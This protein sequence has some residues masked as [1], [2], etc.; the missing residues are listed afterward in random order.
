[1]LTKMI[2]NYGPKTDHPAGELRA[3]GYSP[4]IVMES[5]RKMELLTT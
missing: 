3:N 2:Y 1:M 4:S 5:G